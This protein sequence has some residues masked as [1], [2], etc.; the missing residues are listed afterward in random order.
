MRVLLTLKVLINNTCVANTEGV[1]KQ[2]LCSKSYC[3]AN[4]DG[5]VKKNMYS[6]SY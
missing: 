1:V 6:K 4:A 3:V 2:H 5:V